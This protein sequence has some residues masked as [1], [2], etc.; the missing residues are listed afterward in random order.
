[1]AAA[2]MLASACAS[3]QTFPSK[4]VRIVASEAG[5]SGDFVAR[6][7]A[8]GLTAAFGQQVIVDN[9]GGGVIAGDT[10]AKSPPDGYTLLIYG[11][12]LWLLPLMRKQM[13]YD[14]YRDF[15]PVTLAARGVNVLV[16]HPSLPVKSVKDLVALAR[17]RPG[18]LNFSTA[19]PGTMNHLAGEL[20]KSLAKVNIVRVSY[21]GS[22][23]ALTAVVSGEVQ[24]TFGAAAPVRVHIQGKRVKPLA[25]T[26]AARSP[27]YPELPTMAEAGVPGFEAV[28]VHGVFL[29]VK[30][31]EPMVAR[32]NEEIVRVLQRPESKERLASVGLEPAG[33]TP[34]QLATTIKEEVARMGKVIREAGIQEK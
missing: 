26:T 19:A 2:L 9:R 18:E 31:S 5:G 7:V 27:S 16:V 15:A 1:M 28:S 14:P 20:L 34:A 11:N 12:T 8:Q 6:L 3:A 29:P 32:L 10:V 33:S 13:P 17:A 21:R 4:T 22:P 24:M 25:V 23:S 30:T